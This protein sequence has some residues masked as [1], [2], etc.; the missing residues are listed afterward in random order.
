MCLSVFAN[1]VGKGKDTDVSVFANL[2]RGEYDDH[3]NWPF[4]GKVVVQL[5]VDDEETF[6]FN[7]RSPA[8]DQC[9]GCD[10]FQY[11]VSEEACS[12]TLFGGHLRKIHGHKILLSNRL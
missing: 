6:R 2:M 9:F 4:L 1:G 3:L 10:Y 7:S 5:T 12:I 8:S 11:I